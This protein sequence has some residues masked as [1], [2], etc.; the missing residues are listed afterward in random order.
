[1]VVSGVLHRGYQ[2]AR[3]F[4]STLADRPV[5]PPV[6]V[7]TLASLT[8]PLPEIGIDPAQVIDDL[9]RGVEPGLVASTGPRYFGFVIGG[10]LPGA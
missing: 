7:Q 2:H 6:P 5:G 3:A 10:S 8:G 9:V 1:M 4:L